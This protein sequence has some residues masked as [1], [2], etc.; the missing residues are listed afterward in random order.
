MSEARHTILINVCEITCIF[1]TWFDLLF[2]LHLWLQIKTEN[3]ATKF[4]LLSISQK[5]YELYASFIHEFSS[6]LSLAS[7]KPEACEHVCIEDLAIIS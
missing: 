5:P 6:K 2:L 4:K 7:H 3:Y 1:E